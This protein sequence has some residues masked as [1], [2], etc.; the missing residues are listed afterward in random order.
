MSRAKPTL[1]VRGAQQV[2]ARLREEAEAAA[3]E[4][5]SQLALQ[6]AGLARAVRCGSDQL[7]DD[8]LLRLARLSDVL[9]DEL[10]A[11]GLYLERQSPQELLEDLR[12]LFKRHGV[13]IIGGAVLA[14]VSTG[15]L[16]P[17][18][19]QKRASEGREYG[20]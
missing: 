17:R 15:Y 16:L 4:S 6:V 20:F 14:G 7:Y 18:L 11:A 2:A 12:R 8:E 3:S 5:R 1:V 13:L 19:R 9:A 10:E